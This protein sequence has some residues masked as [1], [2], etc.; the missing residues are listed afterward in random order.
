VKKGIPVRISATTKQRE[1]INRIS[2]LP[3]VK[4]SDTILPGR[5]TIIEFTPDQVGEFTIRN[6]GHGFEGVLKVVE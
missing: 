3:W 1:H 6:I 5:V 4:S 2:I